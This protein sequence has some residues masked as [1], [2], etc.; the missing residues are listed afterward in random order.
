MF[1]NT[2]AMGVPVGFPDA[3]LAPTP[4]PAS[5]PSAGFPDICLPP[6]PS[7]YPNQAQG[8][9]TGP[10]GSILTMLPSFLPQVDPSVMGGGIMPSAASL[11]MCFPNLPSSF[12]P[13]AGSPVRSFQQDHGVAPSGAIDTQTSD[14]LKSQHGG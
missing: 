7:P 4:K 8:I 10:I 9:P 6:S 3:A 5:S 1:A 13:Q 12:L 2:Q 14:A 11:S